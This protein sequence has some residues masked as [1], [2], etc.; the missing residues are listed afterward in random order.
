MLPYLFYLILYPILLIGSV[1]AGRRTA[2]RSQRKSHQW[3]P[4]GVENGLVG[5]YGLLVSFTLVQSGNNARERAEMTQRL[6]DELSAL[7]RITQTIDPSLRTEIRSFTFQS[8]KVMQ[9]K[10]Y[11]KKDSVNAAISNVEALDKKLDVY[12]LD[13]IKTH[14]ESKAEIVDIMVKIDHLESIAYRILHAY[15][16]TVPTFTLFV[17][18]LFSLLVAFM[19][20][21]IGKYNNNHIHISTTVFLVISFI[22]INFI[23]DLNT[24]ARGFIKPDFQDIADV[25]KIYTIDEP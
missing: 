21:F 12:F 23:H 2:T 9:G 3:K 18:V 19:M 11:I 25:I 7:L 1:L 4:L 15:H 16:R 5:F 13:F 17:L 20:G 10:E 22:I 14:P 8:Y 6:A 24:P